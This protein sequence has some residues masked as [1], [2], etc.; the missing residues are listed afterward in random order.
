M[1]YSIIPAETWEL[2]CLHDSS[3]S[4]SHY[5]WLQMGWRL[6]LILLKPCCCRARLFSF[7]SVLW[8]LVI[9]CLWLPVDILLFGA[10]QAFLVAFNNGLWFVCLML[11]VC[12]KEHFF[13]KLLL[14][15]TMNC[16][17]NSFILLCV[18]FHSFTW[19]AVVCTVALTL[20]LKPHCVFTR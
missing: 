9:K 19:T 17:N 10:Y 11:P 3:V 2:L 5:I 4:S 6:V 15:V 20:K 1:I 13:Y 12:S 8:L 14:P 16:F 18:C 7:C